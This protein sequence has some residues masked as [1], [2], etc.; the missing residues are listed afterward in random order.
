MFIRHIVEDQKP[1]F[2][3]DLN[4]KINWIMGKIVSF[5]EKLEPNM[6]FNFGINVMPKN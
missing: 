2:K 6:R 5:Y 3:I 4:Y 1:S